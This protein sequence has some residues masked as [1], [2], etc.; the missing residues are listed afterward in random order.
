MAKFFSQKVTH[1]MF[2]PTELV[3]RK[4]WL[5]VI[6]NYWRTDQGKDS[7]QGERLRKNMSA[8]ETD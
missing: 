2:S 5:L 7:L 4:G 3:S 6:A 1:D 8:R